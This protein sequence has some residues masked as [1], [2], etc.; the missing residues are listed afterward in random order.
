MGNM[1]VKEDG[2]RVEIKTSSE[3]RSIEKSKCFQAS[4]AP[5][6]QSKKTNSGSKVMTSKT[7]VTVALWYTT[8]PS[9]ET[10]ISESF[11]MVSTFLRRPKLLRITSSSE[12]KC[13]MFKNM[14][15]FCD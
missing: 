4:N 9:S 12:S 11:W 1:I 2:S 14:F 10:R 6:L 15:S 13:D 3:K 8:K 7:L 5:F